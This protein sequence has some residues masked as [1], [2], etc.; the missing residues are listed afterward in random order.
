[1]GVCR[2]D[3][4]SVGRYSLFF[5]SNLLGLIE[6][7]TRH[8]EAVGDDNDDSF[9]AIRHGDGSGV[10]LSFNFVPAFAIIIAFTKADRI[11]GVIFVVALPAFN[12]GLKSRGRSDMAP[13]IR[14]FLM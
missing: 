2:G 6:E 10:Q 8:Y 3:K 14:N 7:M 9:L 1:M 13:I 5:R 12:S 4:D 11:W